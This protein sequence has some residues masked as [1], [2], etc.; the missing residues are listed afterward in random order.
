MRDYL[1][2]TNIWSHW[3]NNIPFV[4][5]RVGKLDSR[6]KIC[7]SSIV[8]GEINHGINA[9]PE[10]PGSE[11]REFVVGVAPVV[12]PIDKHVAE[13]YG[14]LKAILF[15]TKSPKSLRLK[16]ERRKQFTSP[17]SAKE[18][19]TSENDLWIASH[20]LALDLILVTNDKMSPIFEIASN[21]GLSKEIW[22]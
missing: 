13:A 14:R 5:G 21:N 8:W 19:Q 9:N 16:T 15:E 20:A 11:Y 22:D 6:T 1:F 2:D 17:I 10:F 4:I 7:L 18:L 12:L 3:Y